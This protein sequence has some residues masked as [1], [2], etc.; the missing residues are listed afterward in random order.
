MCI[1]QYISSYFINICMYRESIIVTKILTIC[2]T[3][4]D[5]III[6]FNYLLLSLRIFITFCI[7]TK[8]FIMSYYYY[9]K[10]FTNDLSIKIETRSRPR[11]EF[12]RKRGGAMKYGS[13]YLLLHGRAFLRAHTVI[14]EVLAGD[15]V[16]LFR[17]CAATGAKKMATLPRIGPEAPA[18]PALRRTVCLRVLLTVL[19]PLA[20]AALLAAL[21]A[22]CTGAF[23]RRKIVHVG[24]HCTRP[25]DYFLPV[26]RADVAQVVVVVHAH[27]AVEDIWQRHA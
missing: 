1:F 10:K 16:A 14:E 13:F 18:L 24:V 2:K 8:G 21:I 12:V 7:R 22:G 5:V 11:F 4:L 27:T 26:D 17:A 6:Y 19:R 9:F 20:P 3:I 25:C 15:T 23:R